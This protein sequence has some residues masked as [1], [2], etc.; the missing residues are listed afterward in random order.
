MAKRTTAMALISFLIMIANT[1]PTQSQ[2]RVRP[3]RAGRNPGDLERDIARW[4][5]ELNLAR[6]QEDRRVVRL[7]T[8]KHFQTVKLALRAG[9][10]QWRLIEPRVVRELE[11]RDESNRRVLAGSHD[12]RTNVLK[13]RK[14]GEPDEALAGVCLCGATDGKRTVDEL[15]TILEDDKTTDEQIKKK[16]DDLQQVREKAEIE[17]AQTRRE[18]RELLNG[19]RQEAVLMIMRILD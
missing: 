3:P 9:E 1:T 11:L 19:P 2:L 14:Y 13:W 6:Q 10:S 12:H 17:L 4:E 5:A 15:I 8:R 7:L 18:L 16:M